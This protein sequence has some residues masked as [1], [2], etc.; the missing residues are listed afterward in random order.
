MEI[1]AIILCSLLAGI[2]LTFFMMRR[3]GSPQP[4][5]VTEV[6]AQLQAEPIMVHPSRIVV[7]D[8]ATEVMSMSALDP[9]EAAQL[10]RTANPVPNQ[11]L[12]NNS[13][14]KS[15]FEPL[16][17]MAPS[18]ATATAAHSKKLMEVVINGAMLP[19]KDGDG[20]R[21]IAQAPKGFE[22]ARLYQPSNLQQVAKISA[23]WQIASIAVAQKH[24]A[25]ISESLK[26]VESKINDV[27]SFL[28][29]SRLAIVKGAA[30]YMKAARS[31]IGHGEFNELTRQELERLDIELDRVRLSMMDQIQRHLGTSLERDTMGCEGEYKSAL[32]KYRHLQ[33]LVS[34]LTLC[35][36]V[37]LSIW[38]LCSVYPEKTHMLSSR[39][40]QIQQNLQ[41][42]SFLLKKIDSVTQK[43]CD[44]I[45][46][47]WVTSTTLVERRDDVRGVSRKGQQVIEEGLQRGDT[48]LL[49][50]NAV[51][52]DR[53]GINRLLIEMDN[54]QPTSIY[55]CEDTN[56]MVKP[57]HARA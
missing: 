57:G 43:D 31:A 19:A 27:Q 50:I 29:E 55:L 52:S 48:L 51:S 56:A 11:S 40:E 37:R 45:D 49:R 41:E 30:N 32:T 2:G 12:T 17:Q 36:E 53:L 16:T 21:A 6:V 18:V 26:R 46:S 34:Q 33:G 10:L 24:L 3:K 14:L 47:T 4:A 7:T 28:E 38:Y 8:G 42:T 44:L 20:L 35:Q 54:G 1:I 9:Q 22:H 5:P 25:D 23:I 39:L 15:L 13:L